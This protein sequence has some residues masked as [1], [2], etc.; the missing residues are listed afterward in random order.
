MIAT[1]TD[2]ENIKN[3]WAIAFDEQEPFLSGYFDGFWNVKNAII[4][5]ENEKLIGALQMIP[6]TLSVRNTSLGSSYIVGVSVLPE[7]RKKGHS[8]TLMY[9][10]LKEQKKR[11]EAISVLIPFNYEFYEKLGYS[12]CYELGVFETNAQNMQKFDS[13]FSFKVMN[14]P[15]YGDLNEAYNLFCIGKSGYNKRTE[16]DWEYIFFEHKLFGGCIYGMYDENGILGYVSY[17]KNKDKLFIRELVYENQDALYCLLSFIKDNF[18]DVKNIKIRTAAN[19][20]AIP[21]NTVPYAM[22]RIVDVSLALKD[23]DIKDLKINI[24]DDFF[25]ENSGTYMMTGGKISKTDSKDYDAKMDIGTFTQLFM[26]Y[27]SSF[28]LANTKKLNAE[29]DVLEKLDKIFPKM[30]NYINHIMEP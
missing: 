2:K 19:E 25:P 29:K 8:K 16:R 21:L 7:E 12:L 27:S 5:K 6:Y 1:D 3:L 22:A 14:L 30:N 28:E 26:G 23:T 13:S 18:K 17:I 24:S 4:V 20:K 15:D 10:C 9:R 11:G